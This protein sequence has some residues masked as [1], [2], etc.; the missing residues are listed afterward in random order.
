MKKKVDLSNTYISHSKFSSRKNKQ[1]SN[2]KSFF[3]SSQT[4]DNKSKIIDKKILINKKILS[5]IKSNIISPNKANEKK[6]IINPNFI[7][8]YSL[9]KKYFKK[10]QSYR[11][12]SLNNKKQNLTVKMKK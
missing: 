10:S 12:S 8:N 7:N 2:A 4:I 6:E 1:M 3:L 5:N 11:Q 9:N